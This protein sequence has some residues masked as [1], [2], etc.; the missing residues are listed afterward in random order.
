M[1]PL[2]LNITPQYIIDKTGKK[3][4][5]ILDMHSFEKLL[6]EIEEIY[7]GALSEAALREAQEY[8]THDEV[9]KKISKKK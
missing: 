6:E 7:L 3:T 4:G 5:V 2:P 9:K 1:K 8:I